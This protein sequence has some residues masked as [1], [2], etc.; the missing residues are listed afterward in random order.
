[1]DLGISGFRLG[2]TQ[3]LIED[4]ELQNEASSTTAGHDDEYE[5]LNHVHTKDRIENA[6][7]LE[8]WRETVI[9]GTQGQRL[10]ALRDDIAADLLAV[11]NEKK[12]LVDLPQSS[13]FL[14]H[15]DQGITAKSLQQGITK[16]IGHVYNTSNGA[17]PAWD[18]SCSIISQFFTFQ[19]FVDL[20]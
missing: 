9:N 4:P 20:R 10:F 15:A 16:W 8:N 19:V 5:S 11:F 14:M 1:M 13:M 7:V 12:T 18:V 6:R 2:F 3:H 17:W